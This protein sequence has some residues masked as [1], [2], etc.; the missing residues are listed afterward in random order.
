MRS[1]CQALSRYW[2]DSSPKRRLA[3][4]SRKNGP[5]CGRE[6]GFF[7]SPCHNGSCNSPKFCSTLNRLCCNSSPT[8][9]GH[10][11]GVGK[12]HSSSQHC[13]YKTC[14]RGHGILRSEGAESEPLQLSQALPSTHRTCLCPAGLMIARQDRCRPSVFP[15]SRKRCAGHRA[16]P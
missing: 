5:G 16:L 14:A 11:A 3:L 15:G 8:R 1:P 4:D 12:P 13:G 2:V 9:C 10:R 7:R 6:D